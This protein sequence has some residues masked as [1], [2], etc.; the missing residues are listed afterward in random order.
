MSYLLKVATEAYKNDKRT[1]LKNHLANGYVGAGVAAGAL[2][3]LTHGVHKGFEHVALNSGLPLRP[4]ESAYDL[5]RELYGC[6]SH[7]DRHKAKVKPALKTIASNGVKGA[8]SR[9]AIGG[10]AGLGVHEI[11]SN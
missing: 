7:L 6:Y 8:L 1:F 2:S 5:G 9:G 10:L 4:G 11:L 3:G